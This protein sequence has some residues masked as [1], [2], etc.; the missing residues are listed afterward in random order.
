MAERRRCAAALAAWLI[1]MRAGDQHA[2]A[3]AAAIL[4]QISA[5][6]SLPVDPF[7]LLIGAHL[8]ADDRLR[9]DAALRRTPPVAGRR[10]AGRRRADRLGVHLLHRRHHQLLLVALRAADRRRPAPCSSGA[11]ALLVATLSAR[12]VRR[13]G[14]RAVPAAWL[15]GL[16]RRWHAPADR[17]CPS[18]V[19]G[20]HRRAERLRLLRRRAARAGRSPRAC[21]RP[22]RASSRRRP[23]SPTC[24]RCNQHVIDS[25]PSGLV[26]TDHS[27]RD[28][29]LQPR[30]RGD[31]RPGCRRRRSGAPIGEVLQ[32]PR[33][34]SLPSLEADLG[35]AGAGASSSTFRTADGRAR[36]RSA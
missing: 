32:L 14:P 12:A 18:A 23:R 27:G 8:R 6:G 17:R 1:A 13:S 10:A 15:A 22:A 20:L 11:A 31:H 16:H 25:L 29:D 26:T 24:R 4:A 35:D 5:P 21:G 3:R 19:G 36:S 7:F 2:P 33:G 28:P 34:A 30:G 9:R